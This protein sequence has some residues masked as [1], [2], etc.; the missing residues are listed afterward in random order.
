[1]LVTYLLNTY[2]LNE[3][4]L[5]YI[6]ICLAKFSFDSFRDLDLNAKTL[7]EMFG[8][9]SAASDKVSAASDKVVFFL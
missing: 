3:V 6:F 8:D 5:N 9:V 4:H 7:Y 2:L 1:M